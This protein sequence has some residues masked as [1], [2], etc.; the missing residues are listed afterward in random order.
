[1]LAS[2]PS[3]NYDIEASDCTDPATL[4]PAA[5]AGV[6]VSGTATRHLEPLRLRQGGAISGTV[7]ASHTGAQVSGACVTLWTAE[8]EV[9][10]SLYRGF[11]T[12]GQDPIGGPLEEPGRF[13]FS[14]VEP[15]TYRV[16]LGFDF[17]GSSH[18]DGYAEVWFRDAVPPDGQPLAV[19]V[20]AG[21]VTE[22]IDAVLTPAASTELLCPWP[23]DPG[24]ADIE[25]ASP[26]ARDIACALAVGL[27]GG[28]GEELW[29]RDRHDAR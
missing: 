11:A 12:S 18:D 17:C 9:A 8:A 27:M 26:H 5:V 25:E 24:F 2:L 22:G 23:P 19:E 1:M 7:T 4:L 3:G 28:E 10:A 13:T 21:E 16:F 15:G 6:T 20:V 14:G 29:T